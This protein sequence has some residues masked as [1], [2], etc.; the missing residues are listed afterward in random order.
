[1]LDEL[2]GAA[3]RG[4]HPRVPRAPRGIAALRRGRGASGYLLD[5]GYERASAAARRRQLSRGPA[6]PR[7]LQPRPPAPGGGRPIASS[8]ELGVAGWWLDGGEGPPATAT[9]HGGAAR[10][11]HNLYDRFRHEAF[12]EGEARDRPDRRV[13]PALPLGGRGHAALRRDCWS[14]DINNDFA[15]ARGADPARAQHR[16]SRACRTGAPTSAASSIRPGDRRALRA[17]VPARRVQPDLPL[18]RL[19][20][21]RARAV[22]PRRARSRR[23]AGNT[24]SCATGCCP[25]RTRW[26]GRPTRSACR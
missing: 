21:A 8:R 10:L 17:L 18:A 7:F 13:V 11:L 14:G 2:R 4:H 22:G 5:D 20:V 15:D 24:P 6:L 25:T 19:G 23:S 26:P 9:L 16:H 3:L 12:A 1:M